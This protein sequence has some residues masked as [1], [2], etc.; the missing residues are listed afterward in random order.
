MA[1]EIDKDQVD[2][3]SDIKEALLIKKTPFA[4]ALIYFL[5]IFVIAMITWAHFAEVDEMTVGNGKIIPSSKVKKIQSLE[6]GIIKE[7]LVY[8]GEIV[9]K[10]Q[11]ILRLDDTQFTSSYR[12]QRAKYVPLLAQIARLKAEISDSATIQWPEEINKGLNKDLIKREQKLFDSRKQAL[13]MN[14]NVLKHSYELAKRELNLTEPLVKEGVMSRVELLRVQRQVNELAGAIEEKKDKFLEDAQVD[15]NTAKA[16]VARIKEAIVSDRDRL[17]RTTIK[18]PVRGTIKSI[19]VST[20]G[21]VIRSGQD[22]IEI[23]PIDDSLL[24]ETMIKPSDI[25]FI[26]AGQKATVKVT[27]YDYSIYGGLDGKIEYISA[28]TI[29]DEEGDSFYNVLVRTQKNHLGAK[30]KPLSIITGMTVSVHILTG[31]KSILN[32]ILKPLLK[33]KQNAFQER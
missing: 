28:D 18:S 23:V 5:A 14:L 19:H 13:I 4:S 31:R 12:E 30:Q 15:L 7:I 2:Y 8:E 32:Y 27:A 21:E 1:D 10:N 9:E 16:E 6:G 24:V 33:A 22:I 3:M 29:V 20:I 17:T 26:H 25:G 11:V